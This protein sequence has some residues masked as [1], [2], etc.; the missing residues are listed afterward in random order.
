MDWLE[1]LAACPSISW[2]KLLD[3][4]Y[5]RWWI[6]SFLHG[7]QQRL[8]PNDYDQVV[9]LCQ[10]VLRG[11]DC[12]K[13]LPSSQPSLQFPIMIDDLDYQSGV[14][15]SDEIAHMLRVFDACEGLYFNEPPDIHWS[16][17]PTDWNDWVWK[18]IGVL[19]QMKDVPYTQPTMVSF[20]G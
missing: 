17:E 2:I 7:V 5:R 14:W 1:Y 10:K 19:R 20:I 11:Y 4:N 13:Q 16:T 3:E 8:T 9:T 18:M 6:G 15:T 12:G